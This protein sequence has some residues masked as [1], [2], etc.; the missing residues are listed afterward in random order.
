MIPLPPVIR[1]LS[2][3]LDCFKNV[4]HGDFEMPHAKEKIFFASGAELLGIYG[5]NGSGKTAVI[6]ALRCIQ[7][8]LQ[9]G[10]LTGEC[11]HLIM[12]GKREA[13]L[14]CRFSLEYQ[15]KRYF[16]DYAICLARGEDGCRLVEES[17]AYAPLLYWKNQGMKKERLKGI[18][19][20]EVRSKPSDASFVPAATFS[21]L[22]A[23]RKD[24]KQDLLVAKR[25]SYDSTKSYIFGKEAFEIFSNDFDED[26]ASIVKSLQLFANNHMTVIE[27]SQSGVISLNLLP[28]S[29]VEHVGHGSIPIMLT[30]SNTIPLEMYSRIKK[31]FPHLNIVLQ[32]IIPGLTIDAE[33]LGKELLDNGQHA[34]RFELVSIRNEA[35]I[36]LRYES[37]GIKKIISI[38]GVLTD[39]Y[40]KEYVCLVIDELDAGIFEYLLGELL[41]VIEE[42]GKGQL[43]FTSHNLRPLEMLDKNSILF[44]T[45]NPIKRYIRFTGI[46]KN[47][48][49]RDQYIRTI[50]LSGQSEE[51]YDLTES[52]SIS[53]AFRKAGRGLQ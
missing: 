53:Q 21:K 50:N 47:H 17:L 33:E 9:G 4:E 45:I 11:G 16:V 22:V 37:E 13:R 48:N 34:M 23:N 18:A 46:K 5:Q 36:P 35:R 24:L 15:K 38:L 12:E 43:I 28:V 10:A 52:F 49:L 42:N 8:L 26:R 27:R 30:S 3:S 41:K 40:N 44:S 51:I 7:F 6:D 25:M 1:L 2:L 19:S 39:M 14:K 20:F 31:L 29:L 32:T